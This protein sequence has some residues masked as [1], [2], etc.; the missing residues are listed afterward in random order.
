MDNFIALDYFDNNWNDYPSAIAYGVEQLVN[1]KVA[2]WALKEAILASIQQ[3]GPYFIICPKLALAHATPG[4]YCLKA[5]MALVVFKKTVHF[6][7]EAK[8]DV[9]IL[10]TLSAPDSS[11]HLNLLQKFADKFSDNKLVDALLQA[12][13]LAAVKKALQ[14]C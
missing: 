9:K 12:D 6:S 5:A 14:G 8:H 7:S 13:S 2:T 4:P 10:I 11:T 1:Q 3:F